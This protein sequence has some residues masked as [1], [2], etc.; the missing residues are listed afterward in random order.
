[1]IVQTKEETPKVEE[2]I[3]TLK[4]EF[5]HRYSYSLFGLGLDKTIMVRQSA[6]VGA[7]IT[8]R[9]S[10]IMVDGTFPS[11]AASCFA[12]ILSIFAPAPSSNFS[13]LE[14]N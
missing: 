3:Q 9:E 1:M 10:E 13:D 2:L 8:I 12:T 14:K 5:S 11:I 7:Q 4:K 6:F